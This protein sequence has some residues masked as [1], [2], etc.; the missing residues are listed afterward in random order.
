MREVIFL[1]KNEKKWRE[2]EDILSGNSP[3]TPD[4]LADLYIE[5]TDDLAF[6]QTNYPDSKTTVYLNG[7]TA[8]IY[9]AVYKNKKEKSNR[10]VNFWA[11]ELPK[12]FYKSQKHLLYA[13]LIFAVSTLIGIVSTSYDEGFVRM[14][15][16]D[17]YVNMTLENIEKGDPMAVYKSM[18]SDSMFYRITINNIKVSFAA[19]VLGIVFSLG[20]AWILF[21]NGVMLGAFQWF[22]YQKGLFLTSF[23]AVWIHGT[24][25]ISAIIIAGA[26]GFV[27]GN[28]ILFPGTFSRTV[29]LV[30][31]ARRAVKICVG[32]IPIFITAG[33]L[34][35]YVT[36]L[37]E[38]PIYVKLTIIIGSFCF[39]LYYFVLL[40]ILL[41]RKAIPLPREV[42]IGELKKQLEK[43]ALED[44]A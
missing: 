20:T 15:L 26:A 35:S 42:N 41:N 37:T 11:Q 18:D 32:L 39:I 1:R 4:K 31:G 12:E 43:D 21:S 10:F 44:A 6:S 16:G 22:F 24:L 34:E 9:Q 7:I 3:A 14:I 19:F 5:M 40:P 27:L 13:F 33:F 25:E 36:R 2:V 17:D 28:S 23:L 8:E 30:K 38:A 29:S